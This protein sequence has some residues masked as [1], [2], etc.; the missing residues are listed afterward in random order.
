VS[1]DFKKKIRKSTAPQGEDANKPG[2]RFFPP[3]LYSRRR[4]SP[5]AALGGRV[6]WNRKLKAAQGGGAAHGPGLLSP[7]T[8]DIN[9]KPQKVTV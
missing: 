1:L 9:G 8:L 7:F 2:R 3:R 5:P 4:H 6:S